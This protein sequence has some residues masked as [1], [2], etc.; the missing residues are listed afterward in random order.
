[1]YVKTLSLMMMEIF[2][3]TLVITLS[4]GLVL[5]CL[6]SD[7]APGFSAK[8][9]R[10]GR[11][12]TCAERAAGVDACMQPSAEVNRAGARKGTLLGRA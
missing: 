10:A 5:V 12:Q 3:G 6:L 7:A 8:G 9:N 4:C 2:E 11:T 1:M